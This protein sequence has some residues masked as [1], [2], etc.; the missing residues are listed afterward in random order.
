MHRARDIYPDLMICERCCAPIEP[1]EEFVTLAHFHRAW[2][3][4]FVEW[5]HAYVH[6]TVC[7]TDVCAER[8]AARRR[9]PCGTP[10]AS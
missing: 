6:T 7:A 3:D 4:G 2:S 9:E 1:C 10:E 5:L 8:P